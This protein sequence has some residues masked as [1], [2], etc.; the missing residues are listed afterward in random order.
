MLGRQLAEKYSYIQTFYMVSIQ[1]Y[2]S[3]LHAINRSTS[4]IYSM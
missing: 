3:N 2:F 1:E 4:L